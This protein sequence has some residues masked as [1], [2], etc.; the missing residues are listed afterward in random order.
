MLQRKEQ[1]EEMARRQEQRPELEDY[2][3]TCTGRGTRSGLSFAS[4]CLL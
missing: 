2:T 3:H 4:L 1:T